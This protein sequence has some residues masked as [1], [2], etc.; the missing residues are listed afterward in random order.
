M[1]AAGVV[2]VDRR[3]GWPRAGDSDRYLIPSHPSPPSFSLSHSP[4]H[5]PFSFHG[6]DDD[7]EEKWKL[8]SGNLINGDSMDESYELE[9]RAN[10]VGYVSNEGNS[11]AKISRVINESYSVSSRA[12]R[13]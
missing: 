10:E 9:T 11:L 4:S 13:S 8:A 2:A 6:F 12:A 7:V 5:G 3:K 1:T